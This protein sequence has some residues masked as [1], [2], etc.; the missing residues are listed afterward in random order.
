MDIRPGGVL[1]RVK[2]RDG[3]RIPQRTAAAMMVAMLATALNASCT[4]SP[5]PSQP[6]APAT[7]EQPGDRGLQQLPRPVIDP[8]PRIGKPL[9]SEKKADDGTAVAAAPTSTAAPAAAAGA[10]SGGSLVLSD[11]PWTFDSAAGTMLRTPHWRLFT[12]STR[13]TMRQRLPAFVERA[14]DHYTSA[15]GEL[16]RPSRS[17]EIFVFSSRAQW[18]SM[19]RRLM[20]EEADT[21]L[22]IQRGGF[23]S[24]GQSVLW[25]IGPR[26]TYTMIAHEA[27]HAYTQ[28]TFKEP[29]PVSWEEALSTYMEGFRFD[30]AKG[31][32]TFRP[33]ANMERFD[34]LR[35]A[36]AQG[37][38]LPLAEWQRATP[39]RLM[40]RSPALA[41]DFYAQ[42]WAVVHFLNEG[43]EGTHAAALR[44]LV[45]DAARGGTA[46]KIREQL[47]GRAA[48]A[49]TSRRAGVDL[50][51]V[52]TGAGAEELDAEFTAFV[53]RVVRSGA[54]QFITDGKSPV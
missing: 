28:T 37:R 17:P 54:R 30:F 50:F 15:L 46:A 42:G 39:Q 45:S 53:E 24:R 22:R 12:T 3:T 27:W 16:P 36:H 10:M 47:G 21:Y 48:G 20:G 32:A 9:G 33:W 29:L 6:T 5:A 31:E 25:E 4:P 2:A 51:K 1:A 18:E 7:Q 34:R 44:E 14:L 35:E 11:E 40:E 52:Y 43:Q 19:T 8:P 13:Q 23:T 41:L 38:L 26:D 49:Y